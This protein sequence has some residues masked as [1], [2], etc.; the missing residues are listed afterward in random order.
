MTKIHIILPNRLGDSILTLPALLCLKQLLDKHRQGQ[1]KVTVFSHF[2]LNRY[3]QALNLFE[4]KSFNLFSKFAS[5]IQK[6]DKAFFLSTT[7]NNIGYCAKTAYGLRLPHKKHVHYDANLPYLNLMQPDSSLPDN[8]EWVHFLQ[9]NYSLS[10]YAARHFGI[11][12]EFGFSDR[13]IMDEFRFDNTSLLAG[14]QYSSEAPLF[15]SDYVVF[16]MEAAYNSKHAANRRWNEEGF[17]FLADKLHEDHGIGSVFIGLNNRPPI[18]K[19]SYL[20]DLR[21]Q[22]T[23]DQT[24]QVLKHSRGYIGND[25]GPL[26]MANLLRKKSIGMYPPDGSVAYRPMFP[27]YNTVC[28]TSQPPEEI[29]PCLEQLLS[30]ETCQGLMPQGYHHRFAPE[31]VGVLSAPC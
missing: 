28:F 20:K 19:K 6:P 22:L 31:P 23:L 17:L 26:H 9:S 12:L 7:S 25:T 15:S 24:L 13:H 11:C 27:S 3:F 8:G 29:Y 4:F 30:G 10:T 2:P 5:W 18:A 16:C 14:T 21:S 1:F